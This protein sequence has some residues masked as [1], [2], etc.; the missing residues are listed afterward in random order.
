MESTLRGGWWVGWLLLLHR[1]RDRVP[2]RRG[3]AR[4]VTGASWRCWRDDPGSDPLRTR[5][6]VHAPVSRQGPPRSSCGAVRVPSW[7]APQTRTNRH[8]QQRGTTRRSKHTRQKPIPNISLPWVP[9]HSRRYQK[10]RVV[11]YRARFM[12]EEQRSAAGGTGTRTRAWRRGGGGREGW[13]GGPGRAGGR[14]R[15]RARRSSC[16][17]RRGAARPRA[18]RGRGAGRVRVK[19]WCARACL[20]SPR[21]SRARALTQ[22]RGRSTG[23]AAGGR[24][25]RR[26]ARRRR[27]RRPSS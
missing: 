19:V 9:L 18:R 13:R 14:W 3:L 26:P 27:A 20:L 21:S 10:V 17:A 11:R 25:P 22:S 7:L 1:R 24:L 23:G 8:A 15:R 6:P 16:A 5:T 4:A 2:G 12:K